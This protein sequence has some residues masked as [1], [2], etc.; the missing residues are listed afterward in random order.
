[1]TQLK[2][3]ILYAIL[4]LV[5]CA[6]SKHPGETHETLPRASLHFFHPTAGAR[7]MMGDSVRIQ[8]V[9]ISGATLHG[10]TLHIRSAT[11]TTLL[12]HTVQSHHHHDTLLIDQAWKAMA[13]GSLEA[14]LV[15]SLNHDGNTQ[16]GKIGFV[17]E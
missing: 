2:K 1:M 5:F 11:D 8:A 12:F 6:C 16:Q 7:F 3:T 13:T 14:V 9:A 10:Y 4:I 17:V 15:L